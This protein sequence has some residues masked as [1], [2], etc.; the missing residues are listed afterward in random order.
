[1]SDFKNILV[2]ID[3]SVAT[4][5]F[6]RPKVLNA[7]STETVAEFSRALTE[8]DSD[9][10]VRVVLLTG[11]GDKAFV[12][13]A[14]I[15]ELVT[16]GAVD[17]RHCARHGQSV[18]DQVEELSKPVVAVINGYALGGGCELALAC[19]LRIASDRA[20][21]GLPEINLG[22]IPG[23]GGTQ[24]LPRLI[25]KGRALDLIC[26]GRH[27]SA[28]EAKE[29]GLVNE[30]VPHDELAGRAQELAEALAEKAPIALRYC[31]EAVGQGLQTTMKEGQI[32]ESN[33]FGILCTTEDKN[34]GMQ[35]FL[36]KRKA[37]WK[38]K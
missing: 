14:D 16:Y 24:R 2:E 21:L 25:G 38:G 28:N 5:T 17:G 18:F 20:K 32:I 12:A 4:V 19:H 34:E 23:H 6:N 29:L 15:S 26:T 10:S 13:G 7:L 1:M 27:V 30:V 36:D 33:L 35:A 37:E 3:G 22:I 11:A 31:L 8:L 9:D